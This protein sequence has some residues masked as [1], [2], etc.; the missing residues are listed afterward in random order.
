MRDV[1]VLHRKKS[2]RLPRVAQLEWQG[3]TSGP[4]HYQPPPPFL[5]L[6]VW[7][8]VSPPLQLPVSIRQGVSSCEL[9]AGCDVHPPTHHGLPS[10]YLSII[11]S[12][13][14]LT[15]VWDITAASGQSSRR[16]F[17]TRSWQGAGGFSQSTLI[18]Q[19]SGHC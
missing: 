16:S 13:L 12:A 8:K 17:K 14:G 2:V 18:W 11:A 9:I 1:G 15:F 10:G 4:L 3:R 5:V 6:W 7:I 19:H